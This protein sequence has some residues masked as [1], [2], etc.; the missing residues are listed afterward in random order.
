MPVI[1]KHF[2]TLSSGE[3]ISLFILR[4]GE[5]QASVTDYGAILASLLVPDRSGVRED[6]L[7]GFATLPQYASRHP[8]FGSTVGRFANRLAGASFTLN[9]R[10]FALD[11]ND[12]PNHLH[13]GIKGFDRRIWDATPGGTYS[14]PS[15]TLSRTSPDGEEG[16]PGTLRAE[17]TFSLDASGALG[18]AYRAV[19]DAECPVNLTNHAYFNLAGEGRGGILGHSVRLAC[20]GYLPVD[21]AQ[22]PAGGP[23]PV[24]GTPFDFRATKEI[25]RDIAATGDGYDH[26]YILDRDAGGSPGELVEFADISEPRYGRR[27]RVSTTLPAVQFYTGNKLPGILGKRGSI[28]GRNAGFCL[29]TQFYPDSPNRPD[30]PS[31]I[32]KPGQVWEHRTV[33][34]FD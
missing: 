19:C 30:F 14:A 29:E 24:A 5:F 27:M 2:G 31:C 33:Y 20:S 6:V 21:T 34:R 7:L 3:D 1:R 9:G 18:I 8:F 4:A 17:V 10:R 26:C 25:G 15:L 23:A 28:Y 16:Y 11:A 12:G 22:I 32:L 13:G